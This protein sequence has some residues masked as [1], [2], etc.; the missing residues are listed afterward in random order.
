MFRLKAKGLGRMFRMADGGDSVTD[1]EELGFDL[2]DEVIVREVGV[3]HGE[4]GH[5]STVMLR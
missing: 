2:D 1:A 4:V 3:A 5:L